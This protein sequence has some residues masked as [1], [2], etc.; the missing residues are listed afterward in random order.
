MRFFHSS[1]HIKSEVSVGSV[2]AGR[3]CLCVRDCELVCSCT[4]GCGL[5]LSLLRSGDWLWELVLL[6]TY[7][8]FPLQQ[9]RKHMAKHLYYLER[10]LTSLGFI[11]EAQTYINRVA[12]KITLF[13]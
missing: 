11:S 2:G 5:G 3:S 10:T 13:T 6:F 9:T 1:R 8:P 12:M 7:L 4:F